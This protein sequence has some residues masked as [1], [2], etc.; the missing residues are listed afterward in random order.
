MNDYL[1]GK[2]LNPEV[3]NQQR[4]LY[5]RSVRRLAVCATLLVFT[6][7]ISLQA[8]TVP[9]PTSGYGATGPFGV[10]VQTFASPLLPGSDVSVFL[11][12]GAV[13]PVPTILFAH[14]F[15]GEETDAYLG[16]LNNLTSQG[17]GVVFSPYTNIGA[18]QS[19][20]YL[21]MGAGFK[22]AFADFPAQLDSSRIGVV[23]HS[24]GGGAVPALT[25]QG[26]VDEGW[27]SNAAFMFA[28]A[29]W[30]SYEISQQQ[31]ETFPDHVKMV[32][33]IY[34]DDRIND[35]R[36]AIDIFE[37]INIPDS[38][39]DF[40][41][42]FSDTNDGMTQDANHFTPNGGAPSGLTDF[43]GLDFYGI[44]RQLDALADYTFNGSLEGK[45]V[46]LG[47]G[48]DEQIFMGNW[49][50]GTPHTPLSVT[51]DPV[52]QYPESEFVFKWSTP[53]LRTNP[54]FGLVPEP[55]S[56]VLCASGLALLGL[57]R[58]RRRPS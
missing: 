32:M 1:Q 17:Y 11:P 46:A 40:I 23:G 27:G 3:D 49:P 25:Y 28:M 8:A 2:S 41:T 53:I 9:P 20:R 13:G 12:D 48:S 43:D 30:Y 16:L 21:Q 7:G 37:N 24:L 56:L 50:D 35:H 14:G 58:L 34:D 51:D 55:T 47:N 6:A 45:N 39:K 10:N 44:H 15:N 57:A 33:Q 36:M 52:P 38:E 42:V 54:R 4:R 26:I 29:P 22:K 5:Q 19:L 18:N 31:L